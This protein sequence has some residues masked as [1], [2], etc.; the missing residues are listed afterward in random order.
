MEHRAS[1]MAHCIDTPNMECYD[2][3]YH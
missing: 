3:A 2:Y 1:G